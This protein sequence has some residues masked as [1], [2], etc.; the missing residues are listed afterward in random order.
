MAMGIGNFIVINFGQPVIRGDGAGVGE[1]KAADRIGNGGIFLNAP[2]VKV[3]IIVNS[4]FIVKQSRV[5]IAKLLPLAAVEDISL[6]DIAV[7]SLDQHR[8]NAVLDILD[9]NAVI[10]NFRL[11]ISRNL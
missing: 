10:F 6:G 2:V 9:G 7:A 5:Q 11:K 1:D 8:F 4:C 3:Y